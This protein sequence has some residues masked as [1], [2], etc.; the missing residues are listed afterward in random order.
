MVEWL[1]WECMG[2]HLYVQEHIV[3]IRICKCGHM[4]ARVR[5]CSHVLMWVCVWGA[6]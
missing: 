1:V 4:C 3:G 5:V 2:V 6:V